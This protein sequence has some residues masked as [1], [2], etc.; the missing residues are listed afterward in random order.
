MRYL[1]IILLCYSSVAISQETITL[2]GFLK[3]VT[4]TVMNVHVFNTTSKKGTITNDKGE[5][6]I[7]VVL[8]DQIE[9]TSIQHHK[10]TILITQEIL[11]NR[12]IEV[13]ILLRDN[14]LKEVEVTNG[15]LFSKYQ[16]TIDPEMEKIASKQAKKTLNFSD[17]KIKPQKNYNKNDKINKRLNNVVDP[18][19]KFEGINLL[20]IFSPF[21]SILKSNK[22]KKDLAFRENFPKLIKADLGEDFFHQKL[23]IPKDKFHN[24]LL[25]CE[26]LDIEKKYQEGKR[27]EVMDI[28]YKESKNYLKILQK[29]K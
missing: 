3:D 28:F 17:V 25:Y 9:M 26:S 15:N 8:D 21:K 7:Q 24:F 23:G 18:T 19:Q 22:K 20:K 27:L 5:F 2:Q 12:K 4:G 10:K 16:K 1:I 29:K 6:T 14:L 11:N 13:E